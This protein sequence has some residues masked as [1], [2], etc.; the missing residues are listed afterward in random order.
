[1][2]LQ[3]LILFV[4]TSYSIH[5]TKLYDEEEV[6]VVKSTTTDNKEKINALFTAQ[7]IVDIQ[8]LIRRIP[9][10]DNVIESYNFV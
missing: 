7:Q 4:I 10:A 3:I 6:M 1:M 5:Y 8:H 9:V 2:S